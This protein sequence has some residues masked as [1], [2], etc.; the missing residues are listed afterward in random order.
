MLRPVINGVKLSGMHRIPASADGTAQV[1]V[2][3]ESV[4]CG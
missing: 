3:E 1:A 2:R 4:R